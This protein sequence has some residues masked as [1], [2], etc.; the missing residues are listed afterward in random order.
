M[1]E[2]FE[3]K[4]EQFR[5]SAK[6]AFVLGATGEIGKELVKALMKERLFSKVVLFGRRQ[7]TYEDELY[8][9]VVRRSPH[10]SFS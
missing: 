6:M 9:D 7:V 10:I 5:G 1:A 3:A 2:E 4:K 8:K